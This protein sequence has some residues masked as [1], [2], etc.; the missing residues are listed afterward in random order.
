MRCPI[1]RGGCGERLK[2]NEGAF[3]DRCINAAKILE[4]QKMYEREQLLKRA[5]KY[6]LLRGAIIKQNDSS[7]NPPPVEEK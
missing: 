6:G 2:P 1:E 7:D 5:Y 3:C 4:R